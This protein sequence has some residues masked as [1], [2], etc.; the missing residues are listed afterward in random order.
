MAQLKGW[1]E[2]GRV[3]KVC[4]PRIYLGKTGHKT[5]YVHVDCLIKAHDKVPNE[6]GELY[7]PVPELCEQSN[8]DIDCRHGSTSVLQP[9]VSFSDGDSEPNSSVNEGHVNTP[10]PVVKG[11]SERVRKPVVR[12]NL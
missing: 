9:P 12:L 4:G 8:L 2:F 11:R 3:V 6:I 10:W 7:I 5:R 1:S